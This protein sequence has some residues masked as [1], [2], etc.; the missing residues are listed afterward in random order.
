MAWLQH[1]TNPNVF[2]HPQPG[3]GARVVDRRD[4]AEAF[5]RTEQEVH[6]F[7]A[8]QPAIGAGDMVKKLT[9]ALGIRQ[10]APCARRQAALNAAMPR[11]WRR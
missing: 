5:A 10:C 4:G 6:Q 1:P 7:A 11:V 3:G 9:D 8:R 2:Y